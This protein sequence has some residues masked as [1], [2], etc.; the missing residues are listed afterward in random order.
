MPNDDQQLTDLLKAAAG[1]A[2]PPRFTAGELTRRIQR[3]RMR[4]LAATAG[5]LAAVAAA[6]VVPLQ[7][8]GGASGHAPATPPEA[9]AP[10]LTFIVTVNGQSRAYSHDA[11]PPLGSLPSFAVTRGAD[12]AISVSATVPAPG[13]VTA[14]WLGISA[15]S[16]GTGPN[17]PTGMSP[18]L[19]R[20]SGKVGP[21]TQTF[22]VHWT[23][24][25]GLPAGSTRLLTAYWAATDGAA[26]GP[27]AE[28]DVRA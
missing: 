15:G 27:I 25:S 8:L 12:L 20:A 19:A 5:T 1:Q 4:I 24:P 17:G 26:V 13:S 18:V 21:G 9:V 3:R 22:T 11:A 16:Y 10:A 28:L 23:V 2:S 14:L 7:V 6:I